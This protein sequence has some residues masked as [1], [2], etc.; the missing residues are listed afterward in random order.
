MNP[1]NIQIRTIIP[2]DNREL[3]VIIRNSLE[4]FGAARPGTV[5]FDPTTDHLY[6][7][8]RTSGSHY[9]TALAGGEI[10]GGGGVYPSK[11]LPKGT[12]ELVKMYLQPGQRG[13]GLGKAIIEKCL[14][15]AKDNGYEKV[16][17]ETLPELGKAMSVYE[18]AGFRYLDSPLGNTG[19]FGCDVWM[20]KDL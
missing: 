14:A 18:R 8:F 1:D 5:Y 12:C 10:V 16:Y 4:E 15:F 13:K 17:I 2:G 9:Y 19:H 20:L 6:E 11:G 7:L 3:A